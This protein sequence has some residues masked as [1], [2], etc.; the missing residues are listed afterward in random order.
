[1]AKGAKDG[2]TAAGLAVQDLPDPSDRDAIRA[3][4][5]GKPTEWSVVI[6][7]RSAL[8]VLP[9]Y[10]NSGG[11]LEIMLP[12]F[13]ATALA[14]FAVKH[15][16]NPIGLLLV[17]ADAAY[18]VSAHAAADAA[19][20]AFAASS[21]AVAHASDAVHSA[22]I[23]AANGKDAIYQALRSDVQELQSGA[24]TVQQLAGES[25]WRGAHDYQFEDNLNSLQKALRKQGRHWSVW[26]DWYDRILVGAVS[27]ESEDAAFTDVPGGLPWDS[28]AEAVNAEIERRLALIRDL[29]DL[30][31][32]PDQS[33]APVRVEE[34]DGQI[35]RISERDSPINA[36][37]RDFKDWRDP[38]SDHVSELSTSDFPPG[39]NH[40][41]VRDRLLA[42]SRLLPGEI[43]EVKERQFRIGYEVERFDG[44]IAAYRADRED[45]PELDAARL[46]ELKRLLVA[47]K[48]GLSKLERWEQFRR[49]A[50]ESK[51]REGEADRCAVAGALV[52]M[53][54]EMETQSQYFH[55]ELPATFR[56]LAEAVR[57]W[58]GATK[59][60][61]YGAVKSAENLLSFLGQRAL[62]IG[63]KT[64]EAVEGHISKAVAGALITGLSGAALQL[65]GA[66]PR[67][68]DWLRP[69]LDAVSKLAGS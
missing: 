31:K 41:R 7:S 1:M 19:Y 26:I 29:Q 57:D 15:S 32:V 16:V 5:R 6:A 42:F 65:S 44:L 2:Q 54:V 11:P 59:T 63:R 69:L 43:A 33:I 45:M 38:V 56:F 18:R 13:R 22:S 14:Q 61:V 49:I 21:A 8:R 28:G 68:W 53:A 51:D 37:E 46:E 47:L 55:P 3:W 62:G 24:L 64:F 23:V 20:A 50:N 48:I 35:A 36:A 52:E 40:S 25:I 27:G 60:I 66:L 4:L 34:R 30:P 39:T 10:Y 12:V 17:A 58:P 9:F 67:A